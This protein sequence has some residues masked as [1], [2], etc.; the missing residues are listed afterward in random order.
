VDAFLRCRVKLMPAGRALP[1]GDATVTRRTSPVPALRGQ[2]R[3]QLAAA[4]AQ[5]FIQEQ[6]SIRDLASELGRRPSLVRRLLGEAGVCAETTSC[7]GVPESEVAAVLAA[8]YREGVSIE[9]LSDDT[10]I[11]RRGV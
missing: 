2:Q 5:R 8:R 10:C 11:G 7:V 4:L 9:R 1:P 3:E 6:V